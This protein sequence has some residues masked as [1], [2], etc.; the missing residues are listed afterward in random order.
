MPDFGVRSDLSPFA[1]VGIGDSCADAMTVQQRGDDPAVQEMPRSSRELVARSP[2]GDGKLAVPV[3]LE[4]EARWVIRST[5]PAVVVP[6][7]ILERLAFHGEIL[8]GPSAQH[9]PLLPEGNRMVRHR[10]SPAPWRRI[11][12]LRCYWTVR[13]NG[14]KTPLAPPTGAQGA[15]SLSRNFST[16]TYPRIKH[17]N[18]H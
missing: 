13:L 4:L 3:A 11:E 7:P 9:H 17:G 12:T 2:L 18:R 8:P 15:P 16:P 1:L 5:S 10:E 6:H 14:P